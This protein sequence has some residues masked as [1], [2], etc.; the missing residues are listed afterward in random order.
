MADDAPAKGPATRAPMASRAVLSYETPVPVG[1]V[2]VQKFH[3][4]M[5]AQMC[6]N[7]LAAHGIQYALVNVNANVLGPYVGF[8]QVELQVRKQ[9]LAEAQAV[10][11]QAQV[12]P[13]E[14][15]PEDDLD[16]QVPLPD[17]EGEGKLV[18]AAAFENSR[19][20][21]DAAVALGAVRIECFLPTLAP[22]GNRPAGHGKRFVLR[23]REDDLERASAA[24]EEAR[25]QASDDEPCCPKCGSY[26][27]RRASPP[28]PGLVKFILG[29]GPAAP[30]QLECLR[31]RH[32]WE[33][34]D[35]AA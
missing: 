2:T 23:V 27:V 5:E 15:E 20:L 17:P 18:M 21:F 32:R 14:V 12:N 16:R 9:D 10:L 6:A 31:C 33:L 25:E 1:A 28:W 19:D 35:G 7:E 4:A 26:R 13:M 3:D 34:E 8:S 22:R 29:M 30:R 11:S 24:L